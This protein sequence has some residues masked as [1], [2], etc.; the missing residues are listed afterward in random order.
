M[1]HEV[2]VPLSRNI[3]PTKGG[4]FRLIF[5]MPKGSQC[6]YSPGKTAFHNP[7]LKARV[8][9]QNLTG[10]ILLKWDISFITM[11]KTVNVIGA[12]GL[13]GRELVRQLTG[14]PEIG[15]IKVFARRRTGFQHEKLEE[16]LVYFDKPDS[17]SHNLTG[18]VLFSTMG[19]T[20]KQ[21][22][23]KA[24]QYRVDYTYQYET[25]ASAAKNGVPVFILVSSAG[26]NE[27][28]MVFYSRIKG[29]LDQDVRKL[30]FRKCAVLRPSI[31]A[32][33]RE[34][35]RPAEKLANSV[36]QVFS[37]FVFTRYRPIPANTVAAAMI[38]IALDDSSKGDITAELDEI[39]HLAQ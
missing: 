16:Y 15:R 9:S 6:H 10:L 31:L 26:A 34:K 7:F 27:K 33:E 14:M 5:L 37:R 11:A 22:G 4:R 36:M 13:V 24:A 18:D 19:T 29:K 30:G 21:A 32:G 39:F 12:T 8:K 17:W 35:I 1:Y 28:S 25:A 38:R 3:V 20:L 23:S 2:Q